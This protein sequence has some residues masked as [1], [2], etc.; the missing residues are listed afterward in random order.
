[1][2]DTALVPNRELEALRA[3]TEGVKMPPAA[4]AAIQ[5]LVARIPS[6]PLDAAI[7][8]FRKALQEAPQRTPEQH[9]ASLLSNVALAYSSEGDR[10]SS[11]ADIAL[12]A[13]QWAFLCDGSDSPYTQAAEEARRAYRLSPLGVFDLA[14]KVGEAARIIK[15]G[16]NPYTILVELAGQALALSAREAG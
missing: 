4:A 2:P 11:F 6:P 1:M 16:W 12:F 7:D 5:D 8:N 3:S 13:A 10:A 14:I 15:L 9:L